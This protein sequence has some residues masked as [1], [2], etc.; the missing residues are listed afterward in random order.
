MVSSQQQTPITTTTPHTYSMPS[1][2]HDW[3]GNCHQQQQQQQ[4]QQHQHQQ[5]QL[6]L[7]QQQLQQLH[8][9][10]TAALPTPPPNEHSPLG[11]LVGS[12]GFG[13][14]GLVLGQTTTP[15]L[16]HLHSIGGLIAGTQSY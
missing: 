13:S 10:N 16:H 9:V 3:Y 14:A 6:H 7:Q 2:Q 15:Q 1:Q 4:Q 5:H 12:H 8:Q 11:G